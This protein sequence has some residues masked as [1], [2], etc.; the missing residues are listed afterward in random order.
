MEHWKRRL[1]G[2]GALV[3][4]LCLC[5]GGTKLT[6]RQGAEGT[7]GQ[8][9]RALEPETFSSLSAAEYSDDGIAAAS[10]WGPFPA[11]SAVSESVSGDA[12]EDLSSAV[13]SRRMSIV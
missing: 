9:L 13:A 1:P 12:E 7:W 2:I 6:A 8:M 10:V 3:L 4:A 5:W 11:L